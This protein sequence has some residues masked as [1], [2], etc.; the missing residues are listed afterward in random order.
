[1]GRGNNFRQFSGHFHPPPLSSSYKGGSTKLETS[2]IVNPSLDREGLSDESRKFD[3]K[4]SEIRLAIP[5]QTDK[6]QKSGSPMYQSGDLVLDRR[7]HRT[8]SL[9][10]EMEQAAWSNGLYAVQR[11]VDEEI[12]ASTTA[13]DNS[14]SMIAVE[15]RGEVDAVGDRPPVAGDSQESLKSGIPEVS[16]DVIRVTNDIAPVAERKD[17]T[18]GKVVC[19]E[20]AQTDKPQKSGSPMY[21]SGDLVLDRRDH[22]VLSLEEEMEQA[23]WSNGLYAVQRAVDEEIS[24]SATAFDNSVSMIAV[25]ERGEVDAVGD[26]PPVAGDSQESLKSGIAEVSVEVNR[27]TN[28]IAPV[29][30]RKNDTAGKVVSGDE[31]AQTDKPRKS[32]SPMYQSGDLVLDRRDHRILSLE[33][34]MEQAAWSYGLHAVRRAVDEEISASTTAFDNSVSMIAA[35]ERGEV[36]AV[37]DRP[38]VAGD[39]QESLKSGI[40]EVSVEVNGVTNDIAPVAE[41]KD[42]TAGKVVS[43]AEGMRAEIRC[44]ENLGSVILISEDDNTKF[45]KSKAGDVHEPTVFADVSPSALNPSLKDGDGREVDVPERNAASSSETAFVAMAKSSDESEEEEEMLI[46]LLKPKRFRRAKPILSSPAKKGTAA[47]HAIFASQCSL[48]LNNSLFSWKNDIM[49]RGEDP[50]IGINN[51]ERVTGTPKNDTDFDGAQIDKTII[52]GPCDTIVQDGGCIK[53]REEAIADAS[54]SAW[55]PSLKDSE[56]V[57]SADREHNPALSSETAF[58]TM[59]ESSDESVEEEEMLMH[60]MKPKRFKPIKSGTTKRLFSSKNK[61]GKEGTADE[62]QPP[63]QTGNKITHETEVVSKTTCGKDAMNG[64]NSKVRGGN[65]VS[66]IGRNDPAGITSAPKNDSTVKGAQMNDILVVDDIA[67]SCDTIAKDADSRGSRQAASTAPSALKPFMPDVD[68]KEV[69]G[70]ESNAASSS[71][72]A[73]V[74]MIESSDESEEEEMLI[75][76]MKPKRFKPIKRGTTKRFFSS[77]NKSGKEGTADETQPPDQ[78]GNKIT[79]EKEVVSKTT[80]ETDDTNGQNSKVRGGNLVSSIGRNDPAGIT[81]A[82]KNDST[83]KGVQMNDILVVD[84]IASSCDKIAKDADSRGSRQAASAAPSALKPF[85]PDADGKEVDGPESNAASSSETAFVIMIESSDESEEDEEEMLIHLMKPKRFKPIARKEKR[86]LSSKNKSGKKRTPGET[87]PSD[88]NETNETSLPFP[89][90]VSGVARENRHSSVSSSIPS[91]TFD[92]AKIA[93]SAE[94]TARQKAEATARQKHRRTRVAEEHSYNFS[95]EDALK[96]Q[97]RLFRESAARMRHQAQIHV[98]SQNPAP[99]PTMFDAPVPDVAKRFPFHW[100]SIDMYARLGLHKGASIQLIKSHYR[101]LALV[102]HPDKSKDESSAVKFQAITEAYRTL[103][104]R[105]YI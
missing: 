19:A 103:G 47:S 14:V 7:D 91:S 31:A 66:S 63:D 70:P 61:S 48:W 46:D 26:R 74:I 90:F 67:G 94:A 93:H 39:S 102:Y 29:A 4:K 42:D 20:A 98:E 100:Q 13:F 80:C 65:L 5:D 37:G 85:M 18:A 96:E 16:V 87:K 30:E 32:G 53:W 22:R 57:E 52:A 1:M 69:D 71:E 28:D 45:F 15:E 6:P 97:E 77:K 35:E 51:P 92:K 60:L 54:P 62:T 78:T 24:A 88:Q 38:P 44:K 86:L 64:Q 33:E 43:V 68:G 23:A 9:E 99:N 11:A 21:Q 59:V 75:H 73:F 89:S 17:D 2:T 49:F 82:P 95:H 58:V 8:L 41:R 76:L 101:R 40:P 25:E 3:S 50:D 36:D 105:Y 56:F 72:T 34:E 12:S 83:V 104:G 84:D 55:K 27:V 81:S 79:H 10:E